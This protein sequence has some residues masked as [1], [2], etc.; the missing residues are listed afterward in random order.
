MSQLPACLTKKALKLALIL[1]LPI[2]T[3]HAEQGKN[4]QNLFR[5]PSF[6]NGK[7]PWFALDSPDKPYWKD[8][9]VSKRA[10]RDGDFSA[11]LTVDNNGYT[12]STQIS[13]IIQD[14]TSLEAIPEELS[15]SF[16]I[17]QWSDYNKLYAQVV[18]ILF[19]VKDYPK[20]LSLGWPV[21]IA[22]VLSDMK[23]PPFKI[24]NRKFDFTAA[25]AV[26]P[27]HWVDFRFRLR[28]AFKQHWGVVPKHFSKMRVLFEI[29][30]DGLQP[31]TQSDRAAAHF[32]K[33]FLGKP[34][35][36]TQQNQ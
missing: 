33:L 26:Q 27:N 1:S 14:F 10:A 11:M 15:G 16:L 22:F 28:D 2:L 20:S 30:F 5:N 7:E 13:G 24:L 4:Q 25:K 31:T 8:F 35:A 21:Q 36:L 19:D 23:T 3:S 17:K 34:T 6:E 29:R 9:E 18:V 12:G 32:D